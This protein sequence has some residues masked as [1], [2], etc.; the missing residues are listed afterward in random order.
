VTYSANLSSRNNHNFKQIGQLN[1]TNNVSGY[2]FSDNDSRS[3]AA[4]YRL[5][6]TTTDG[7]IMYSKVVVVFN[8]N[9]GQRLITVAPTVTSAF[10]NLVINS[11][12]SGRVTI[13]VSNM[14]GQVF[15]SQ[16][17]ML[18]PGENF[19]RINLSGMKAGQYIVT[20]I[21]EKGQKTS[22]RIIRN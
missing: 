12:N 15:Q 19:Q 5:K 10:T 22:Y 4:Y 13:G 3:G 11:A 14:L 7:K 1:A 21:D 18:K 16:T 2:E 6:I 8:D 17:M 9:N 20:V